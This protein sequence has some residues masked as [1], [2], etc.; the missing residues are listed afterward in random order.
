MAKGKNKNSGT[1]NGL[2]KRWAQGRSFLTLD[3]FR[4]N[5]FY[6]IGITVLIMMNISKKYE[7]QDCLQ[8]VINLNAELNDVRT[9]CVNASAKFNSKIRESE[10]KQLIDTCH[11]DLTTPDQPPYKLSEK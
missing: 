3:F 6:I 10:M 4:R 8:E 11:I 1:N 9:D 7:Y 5:G 2:F